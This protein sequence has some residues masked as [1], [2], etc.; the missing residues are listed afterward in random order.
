MQF[1]LLKLMK[2]LATFLLT[3]FLI[4]FVLSAQDA[5]KQGISHK[6]YLDLSGK[7]KQGLK[8]PMEGSRIIL[9]E[10]TPLNELIKREEVT[11]VKNGK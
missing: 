9:Y 11:T 1:T 10:I 7:V 4:P 3:I 2:I 5:V 8:N 6:G